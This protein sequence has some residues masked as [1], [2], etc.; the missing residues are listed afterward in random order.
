MLSPLAD[1]I[2]QV[3]DAVYKAQK[4]GRRLRIPTHELLDLVERVDAL[5][6]QVAEKKDTPAPQSKEATKEQ[7]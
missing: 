1:K 7:K 6:K 5:E 4:F 2:K 3:I